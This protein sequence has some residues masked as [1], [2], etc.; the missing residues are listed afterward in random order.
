MNL[1]QIIEAH[2]NYRRARR[3]GPVPLGGDR[4]EQAQRY[5]TLL[6]NQ[7][8]E[9]RIAC[10]TP[11]AVVVLD[12]K[13]LFTGPGRE[14][15]LVRPGRHRVEANKVGREDDI[16]DLVLEPRDQKT[17]ALRLQMPV[18]MVP[19][20]RWAAWRPWG[21]VGGAA[22]LLAGG[23]AIDRATTRSFDVLDRRFYARCA[24]SRGCVRDQLPEG[25]A[26]RRRTI[27][28]RQWAGRAIYTAGGA[29]LAAGAVLVYLNRERMERRRTPPDKA[30]IGQLSTHLTISPDAAGISMRLSF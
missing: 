17:L 21:V 5:M 10:D 12:G 9:L 6:G 8:A 18:R 22:L 27:Q 7:L 25:F 13:P 2:H 14:R 4:Y 24:D 16:R 19:V 26:R 3:Y 29:A 11:G 20:R 1:D 28:H 15:V 30:K 23:A